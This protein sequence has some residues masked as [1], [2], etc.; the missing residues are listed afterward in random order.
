MEVTIPGHLF[1]ELPFFDIADDAD[2]VIVDLHNRPDL[3]NARGALQGGLVATL[4]DIAGGRLAMS[5]AGPD[6]G[7]STADMAIHYLAPIN[8]GPARAVATMVRAGRSIIVVAVDVFDIGDEGLAARATLSFAVV[9]P[10]TADQQAV[11]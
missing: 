5:V 2:T 8:I 7:V 3:A 1:G 4:V 9:R 6:N 11:P 10:R